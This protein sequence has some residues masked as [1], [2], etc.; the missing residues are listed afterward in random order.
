MLIEAFAADAIDR[1]EDDTAL[2]AHL[3]AHVQRWLG[4]KD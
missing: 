2:R 4:R 3:L 1:I